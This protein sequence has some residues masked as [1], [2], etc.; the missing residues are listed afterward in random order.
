MHPQLF[1][2]EDPFDDGDINAEILGNPTKVGK[3]VFVYH[4]FIT[5]GFVSIVVYIILKWSSFM[6]LFRNWL[7]VIPTSPDIMW[8]LLN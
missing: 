7:Y 3:Y 8:N 4:D 2:S 6:L 5:L 1:C